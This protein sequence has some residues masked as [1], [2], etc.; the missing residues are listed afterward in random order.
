MYLM[1]LVYQFPM[2]LKTLHL[3]DFLA[4]PQIQMFLMYLM[5]DL[6]LLEVQWYHWY[7]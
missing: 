3:Q 5:Q 2:Y 1:Y 6:A 4:V 7:R